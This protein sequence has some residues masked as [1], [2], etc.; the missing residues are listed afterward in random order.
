MVWRDDVRTRNINNL[1][2]FALASAFGINA[3]LPYASTAHAVDTQIGV[4][5]CGE[6]APGSRIEISQPSDDSIVDQPTTTFRGTA[7]NTSQIEIEVDGQYTST[8][9][10]GVGQS[11]FSTNISLT[12]GTHTVSMTANDVCGGQDAV[13]NVV[14]TYTP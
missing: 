10:I 1:K 2:K 11:S 4:S 13:D 6:G 3:F 9:A 5:V 14:I 7:N 8:I 12:E